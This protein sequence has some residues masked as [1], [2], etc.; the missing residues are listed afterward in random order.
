MIDSD[1]FRSR[2]TNLGRGSKSPMEDFLFILVIS[3]A[4]A[5]SFFAKKELADRF[6]LAEKMP[7]TEIIPL[8][9]YSKLP[10]CELVADGGG[11]QFADREFAT[12]QELTSYLDSCGASQSPLLLRISRDRTIGEVEDLK[13]ELTRRGINLYT[14]WEKPNGHSN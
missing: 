5:I 3:L 14:E 6:A 9:D 8:E 11:I 7:E 4:V 10:R 1:P 12:V 13:S 2:P